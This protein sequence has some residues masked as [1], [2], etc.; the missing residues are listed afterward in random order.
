MN[1]R[2]DIVTALATL[3]HAARAA[4]P[5]EAEE[6]VGAFERLKVIA[7]GRTV[8][9]PATTAVEEYY[10]YDQ[11]AALLNVEPREVARWTHL[12]DGLPRVRLSRK[13]VRIARSDLDAWLRK[14]LVA[15]PSTVYSSPRHDRGRT[16]A[17]SEAARPHASATRRTHRRPLEQPGALGA[18]RG[19]NHG[20]GRPLN[21][22]ARA[23]AP[24]EMNEGDRH[25][26]DT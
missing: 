22:A 3:E 23:A 14:H 1:D 11:V 9:P 12:L 24:T 4:A 18:R 19:Q 10:T 15:A 20:A 16:S 21:S 7:S 25:G 2:A 8:M 13:V 6:L 17:D 5:R 26:D